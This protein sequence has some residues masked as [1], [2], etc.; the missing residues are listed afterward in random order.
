MSIKIF[1]SFICILLS[2]FIQ[3]INCD[4]ECIYDVD[5][6]LKLDLRTLGFANGKGPKYDYI[7]NANPTSNTFSWN[8]CFPYSKLDQGNCSDAAA[9]YFDVTKNKSILIAK[10]DLVQFKHNQGAS[11]LSYQSSN[12]DLTVFLNCRDEDEDSAIGQQH[13]T[14]TYTIHIQSRCCCPE[15]CHYSPHSISPITI[16]IIIISIV[17]VVYVAGGVIFVRY[18]SASDNRF[19]R[20]NLISYLRNRNN[21]YQQM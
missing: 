18:K 20:L 1:N 4:S 19:S 13:D 7:S 3:I 11:V 8:G 9:C 5:D 6:G 2:S 14:S 17:L 10:Q 15:M 12:G 21:I 16:L